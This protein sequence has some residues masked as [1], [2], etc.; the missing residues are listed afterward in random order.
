MLILP[1][2]S[3]YYYII[4]SK[5]KRYKG[6]KVQFFLDMGIIWIIEMLFFLDRGLSA[7]K[8][9]YEIMQQQLAENIRHDNTEPVKNRKSFMKFFVI[10]ACFGIF[11]LLILILN[12][13]KVF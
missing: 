4:L 9:D 13:F 11:E 5:T 8:K 2:A 10:S 6:G 12:S 3:S 7:I 1:I